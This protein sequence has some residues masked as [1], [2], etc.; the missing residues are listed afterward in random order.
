[1]NF[2]AFGLK[3]NIP[4]GGPIVRGNMRDL[5]SVQVTPYLISFG[6]DLDRVPFASRL[7]DFFAQ[8]VVVRVR[9]VSV[10]LHDGHLETGLALYLHRSRP[11]H[12]LRN[13]QQ[14]SGVAVE[15]VVVF[16]PRIRL[17]TVLQ[18]EREFGTELLWG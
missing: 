8:L 15:I 3:T 17:V 12:M 16:H 5:R 7:A 18:P 9:G 14:V 6:N 1:M 4:R 2:R 11:N 13:E 10:Q